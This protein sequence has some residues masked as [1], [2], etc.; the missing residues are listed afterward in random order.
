MID[1]IVIGLLSLK[2]KTNDFVAPLIGKHVVINYY[3]IGVKLFSEIN[4]KNVILSS[5]EY[6]NL[7][8]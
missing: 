3:A 4:R 8:I 1:C 2:S 6:Y 5:V 7:N